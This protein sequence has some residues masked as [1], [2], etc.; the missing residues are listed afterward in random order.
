MLVRY[1]SI[2]GKLINQVG[3]N[4]NYDKI[5]N[6]GHCTWKMVFVGL[7][8]QNINIFPDD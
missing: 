2:V 3:L 5:L 8:Y 7:N 1:I 6:N 4:I